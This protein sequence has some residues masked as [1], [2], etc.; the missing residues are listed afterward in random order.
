MGEAVRELDPLLKDLHEKKQSFRR[1]ASDVVSLA[2]ELKDVR[3]RMLSQEELFARESKTRKAAESK[4]KSMEEEIQRLQKRLEERNGQLQ[5][6]SSNAEHY[7]KELDDLRSQLSAAQA[8]ADASAASAQSAHLQC[9]TLLQEVDDKNSS[10]QDHEARVDRLGKQIDNLQH[11]L[12]QREISQKELRDEVLRIEREIKLAVSKAGDSKDCELRKLLEEVSPKNFENITKHLSA[13]DEEIARLRDEI[14]IMSAHWKLKTQELE[15]Q[16]FFL[17]LC[18][19]LRYPLSHQQFN[20]SCHT[21]NI[22]SIPIY[23]YSDQLEK[24]RRADQELK[25]RVLKLEFCLQE[26][27]SQTRKL[28]RMGERRDKALKELMEQLTL[29]KQGEGGRS[30]KHSFWET[31]GFKFIVSMSMVVLVVFAKR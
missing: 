17:F 31:S 18:S 8:T 30:E 3:S 14:R 29:M 28:Q 27:R 23:L 15:S 21:I 13:K 7:H 4:A 16:V 2:A 11:D 26:A 1:M 5:A 12:Q 19:C 10:L 22:Y 25:K 9:L 6:S 24:Q 20:F